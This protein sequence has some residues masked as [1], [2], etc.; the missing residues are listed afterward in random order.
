MHRSLMLS[1]LVNLRRKVDH[2]LPVCI[3]TGL[4]FRCRI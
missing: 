2:A 4:P 3:Q 1:A